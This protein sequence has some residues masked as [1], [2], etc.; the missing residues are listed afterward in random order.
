MTRIGILADSHDKVA[1]TARAVALLVAEGAEVLVHC[2]DYTTPEVVDQCAAL[3][4]YYV[5]GNNDFD[6]D[7]LRRA[8]TLVGGSCLE[9]AGELTLAGRRIAVAHGDS[10]K[11]MRR[12]A[13]LGPDY[14]LFGHTHLPADNKLGSTRYINPGALHR[15]ATW[16]VALL[17]LSSDD[18]RFLEVLDQH[19][20]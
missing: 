20:R 6:E 14:F 19:R 16:S 11:D 3:P 15:A 10:V 17:D 9:R 18:L 5:F 1:R 13:A 12:L 4:G 8:M 2:G 7:G